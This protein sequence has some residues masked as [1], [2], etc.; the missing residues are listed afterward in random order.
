MVET[1]AVEKEARACWLQ[2]H[3]AEKA[4]FCGKLCDGPER[5]GVRNVVEPVATQPEK[6]IHKLRQGLEK[7]VRSVAEGRRNTDPTSI[8]RRVSILFGKRPSTSATR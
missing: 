3:G 8:A 5:G 7:I 4:A 6:S 1:V 2:G